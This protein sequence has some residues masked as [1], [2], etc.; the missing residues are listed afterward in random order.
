MSYA[1]KG[2]TGMR[3]LL[4]VGLAALLA[5]SVSCKKDTTDKETKPSTRAWDPDHE[6]NPLEGKDRWFAGKFV[7]AD[8]KCLPCALGCPTGTTCG[9]DYYCKGSAANYSATATGANVKDFLRRQVYVSGGILDMSRIDDDIYVKIITVAHAFHWPSQDILMDPSHTKFIDGHGNVYDMHF[10]HIVPSYRP[11]NNGWE[12]TDDFAIIFGKA[13][14]SRSNSCRKSGGG[15]ESTCALPVIGDPAADDSS[16]RDYTKAM[17]VTE[18]IIKCTPNASGQ[19]AA[20]SHE[21]GRR[22]MRAALTD[23][24]MDHA[25][26][27][28]VRV[29]REGPFNTSDSGQCDSLS[30][31]ACRAQ[32]D[33]WWTGATCVHYPT[34]QNVA[35]RDSGSVLAS[36]GTDAQGKVKFYGVFDSTWTPLGAPPE[37]WNNGA[38]CGTDRQCHSRNCNTSTHQCEIDDPWPMIASIKHFQSWVEDSARDLPT[39]RFEPALYGFQNVMVKENKTIEFDWD[40][41]LD[42]PYTVTEFKASDTTVPSQCSKWQFSKVSSSDDECDGLNPCNKWRFALKCNLGVPD[43]D[44]KRWN[45]KFKLCYTNGD[46]ECSI[47]VPVNIA[48]VDGGQKIYLKGDVNSDGLINDED[49][50][51]LDN[52]LQNPSNG[53]TCDSAADIDNDGDED[54]DDY[55]LLADYVIHKNMSYQVATCQATEGGNCP[56]NTRWCAY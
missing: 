23:E 46:K 4:F 34:S 36:Q 3:S 28:S 35:S 22:S 2:S 25:Y 15:L 41:M 32:F 42:A 6:D 1:N 43:G 55:K 19:C 8:G 38:Q 49:L 56:S 31:T 11:P 5:T 9:G 54:Q 44:V 29:K 14:G 48:V 52:H 10:G 47:E 26:L 50:T 17:W 39:S 12:G 40:S 33:C 51:M 45:R 27:H 7:C 16:S 13:P 18:G 24:S 53:L 37:Y 20:F 30:S 21:F